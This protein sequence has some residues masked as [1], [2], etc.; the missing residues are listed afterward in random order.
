MQMISILSCFTFAY[1]L[2]LHGKFINFTLL[3]FFYWWFKHIGMVIYCF[4]TQKIDRYNEIVA[5]VNALPRGQ[6]RELIRN[7]G[8]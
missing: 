1:Q 8:K 5:K 6:R 3:V 7:L 4:Q 2:Y